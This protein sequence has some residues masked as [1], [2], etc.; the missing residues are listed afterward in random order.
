MRV[1]E[2]I[3]VMTA[4]SIVVFAVV[5]IGMNIPWLPIAALISVPLL[6][7]LPVEIAR[8]SDHL[9][10]QIKHHSNR[11]PDDTGASD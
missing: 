8:H 5:A 2:P 6:I 1:E 11:E 4:L 3:R 7:G 9:D 10:A